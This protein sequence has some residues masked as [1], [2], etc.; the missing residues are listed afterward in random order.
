MRTE[1]G[2]ISAWE[3]Y[4]LVPWPLPKQQAIKG[5]TLLGLQRHML[6]RSQRMW[7]MLGRRFKSEG[8]NMENRVTKMSLEVSKAR[9]SNEAIAIIHRGKPGSPKMR[10]QY[11]DMGKFSGEVS[12]PLPLGYGVPNTPLGTTL[13]VDHDPFQQMDNVTGDPPRSVR[14]RLNESHRQGVFIRYRTSSSGRGRH[15]L[16]RTKKSQD[17]EEKFFL[18]RTLFDD[19]A[20]IFLDKQRFFK[21]EGPRGVE[22]KEPAHKLRPSG[23]LWDDRRPFDP[24]TLKIGAPERAGRWW[25]WQTR[26]ALKQRKR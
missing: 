6:R 2:S 23:V 5:L 14:V 4:W 9:P 22:S 17:A 12:S 7:L 21:M 13:T 18:R 1:E 16:F 20:R 15:L 26:G 24:F 8:V 19:S 10:W 3:V 25:A 11:L